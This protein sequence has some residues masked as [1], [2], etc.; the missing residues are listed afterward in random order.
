MQDRVQQC[1]SSNIYDEV[2]LC[3]DTLNPAQDQ[4]I[5]EQ[6]SRLDLLVTQ[7]E[8]VE[9]IIADRSNVKWSHN[10]LL[11]ELCYNYYE[12]DNQTLGCQ[13]TL[14]NVQ[15]YY[16][17]QNSN[18]ELVFTQ[19]I[20]QA[21]FAPFETIVQLE[22]IPYGQTSYQNGNYQCPMSEQQ[23]EANWVHVSVYV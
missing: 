15:I 21:Q 22:F 4:A 14:P 6:Q 19:M 7:Q 1:L 17:T 12:I 2:K 11:Q 9:V 10:G 16:E 20:Y 13:V 18:V 5:L 8:A 3:V 23:C